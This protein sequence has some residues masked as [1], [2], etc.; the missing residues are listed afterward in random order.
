MNGE[1]NEWKKVYGKIFKTKAEGKEY[2]F[3]TLNVGEVCEIL[4]FF[5]KNS[6]EEA[7]DIAL[8]A[9]LYPEDFNSDKQPN[10]LVK[11]L[12]DDIINCSKVFDPDGIQEIIKS[13]RKKAEESMADNFY[14]WKLSLIQ[15]F[16][17]YKLSDL[18]AL[19]VQE[20]F[21]LLA[22][23]EELTGKK[24]INDVQIDKN[25][26]EMKEQEIDNSSVMTHDKKFLSQ[27]ELE[28]I[29]ADKATKNLMSHWKKH[30]G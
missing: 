10:V 13:A 3:R 15:V 8:R 21:N 6:V 12:A 16:P 28:I 18:D 24:V 22:I 25:I 19:S 23:M 20:F 14:Q 2:I 9:I 11:K 30:K 7:E 26:S 17:A 27:K 5:Q 4:A 1:I 29:S